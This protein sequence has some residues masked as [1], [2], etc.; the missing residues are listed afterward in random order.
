MGWGWRRSGSDS[1]DLPLLDL[2]SLVLGSSTVMLRLGQF[3]QH[4]AQRGAHVASLCADEHHVENRFV[5]SLWVG[6]GGGLVPIPS[7]FPCWICL[8]A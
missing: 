7:S 1:L 3:L 4:H 5:G 8:P 2:P 6:A